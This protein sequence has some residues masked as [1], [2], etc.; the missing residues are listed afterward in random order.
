VLDRRRATATTGNWVPFTGS[1]SA[2]VGNLG[3]LTDGA[4]VEVKP[5]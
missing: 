2:I 3:A 4:A 5:D 1:E